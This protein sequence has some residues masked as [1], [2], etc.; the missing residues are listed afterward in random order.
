MAQIGSDKY[1][2]RNPRRTRDAFARDHR[3]T[4]SFGNES[5]RWLSASLGRSRQ[6]AEHSVRIPKARRA[7]VVP[8]Q[9][10]H[11]R[12][13]I[14]RADPRNVRHRALEFEPV[15]PVARG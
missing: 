5:T 11:W 14:V 7:I 9:T 15:E 8:C 2:R 4:G 6:H 10:G 13:W 3:A 12:D 1:Q